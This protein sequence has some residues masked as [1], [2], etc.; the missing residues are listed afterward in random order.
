MNTIGGKPIFITIVTVA[1]ALYIGIGL[2][3]YFGAEQLIFQ[4][5]SPSYRDDPSII[6]IP[7]GDET[8]S[9]VHL[10]NADARYTILYNHG[11]AED[12]GHLMPI[13]KKMQR[14]GYS[15]FAY[16]YQGY[17]TSSGS[18]T[19]ENTYQDAQA[20]YQYLVEKEGVSPEKIIVLG[21]SLGGA[22]AIDLALNQ[23]V[24]GLIVESSFL[25]AYRVM[26]HWAI[27]P[28]DQYSNIQKVP[29]V[30]VPTWVIHGKKDN[31]IPFWHGERLLKL[32]SQPKMNLWVDEASHNNLFQQAGQE[33]KSALKK[34]ISLIEEVS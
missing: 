4:P 3:A 17:G 14:W 30:D 22:V 29:Q 34:F 28:F 11:N 6:H 12:I 15:I 13:F 23:K 26:T 1:I 21:R 33:Y 31:V 20:A 32:A 27:Y 7:S 2:L 18:P 19:E 5:P 24:G 8:I 25:S 16:D 10:K 9:A